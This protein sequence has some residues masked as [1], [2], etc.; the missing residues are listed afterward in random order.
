MSD[1]AR[2]AAQKIG[3]AW[4]ADPLRRRLSGFA[5]ERSQPLYLVGGAPR[6]I[7]LGRP[8][9]DWDLA[10]PGAAELARRWASDEDL[11]AV[12]LHEDLPTVR[13]IVRPGEPDGFLDFADL[14]AAAVEGDLRARDFTINALAWDVRGAPEVVDPTGGLA[15]LGRRLVR[16]PARTCLR[17]DPLRTLRAFRLAAELGFGLEEETARWVREC[18]P[19]MADMAGERIGREM[20]RLMAAP[21]TADALQ[22]AHE[23]GVLADFVP[24]TAA[25]EGVTQGGYHHLDVMGHTLLALHEVERALNAPA[26]IFPRSADMIAAWATQPH[27]RAAVTLAVLFHDTGKPACRTTDEEGHIR[28]AGHEEEGARIFLRDARRWALPGEVRREVAAMIRMHLRPLQLANEGL[29][30][31]D[32]GL[33]PGEAVTLNAI[34]RIMRDAEPAGVGLMLLAAADRSA[35][36]G[37]SS[38]FER[39]ADV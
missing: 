8:V 28:F 30:K 29:R 19:G 10:G 21:H 31:L 33:P 22:A 4:L 32:A 18:A 23:L 36:R 7:V 27:R 11:R 16:A 5:R 34:R 9:G 35:C 38:H 12:T 2:R 15:D 39:R 25:M 37:P 3:H 14:R 26:E 17:E 1:R 6:D 20:L 24:A 13:V